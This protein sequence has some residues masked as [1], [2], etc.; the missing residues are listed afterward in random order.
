MTETPI[1]PE[2]LPRWVPGKLI[3][4]SGDR[5][6]TDLKLRSYAYDGQDV[7]VPP[8]Q[9]F[10]IVTYKRG[11]TPAHRRSTGCWQTERLVPGNVS[12]LTN[13][14]MAHWRWDEPIEVTHLYLA[15]RGVA[16]IAADVF[17]RGIE[18][19]DLRDVLRVDDP[20]IA[21]I[22]AQMER[23]A[24]GG[25]VGERLYVD[26]LQLQASIHLLR[27][28]ADVG[29]R[30]HAGSGALSPTQRCRIIDYV[31]YA[32]DRPIHLK[33]LARLADLSVFQFC[34]KFRA[35]FGSSPHAWLLEQRVERAKAQLR[36]GNIP[37]KVISAEAG[38]FDQSHMTRVFRRMVGV[39][40]GTY[41][42]EFARAI[43]D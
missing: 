21:H 9:D 25:G 23:E 16:D 18:S 26:S 35:T 12:I 8:L 19:I 32:T 29:F 10:M 43:P 34:R 5:G 14:V 40:P 20:V 4:D 11:H 1:A 37:L 42:A 27:R 13:A 36:R 7:R 17:D 39:T 6:W 3:I 2:D 41:R 24:R 31:H 33:E 22:A 30:E 38:F 28:Y 15:P